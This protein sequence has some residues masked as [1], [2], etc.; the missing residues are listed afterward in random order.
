MDFNFTSEEFS[1]VTNKTYHIMEMVSFD[2][3]SMDLKNPKPSAQM[4]VLY[5]FLFLIV[6]V[7]GNFLLLSMIW[8]EKYGMDSKKRT[9]TNQLLSNIC[10]CFVIQN[11]IVMPILMF[12]RIY[13]P[14]L[15]LQCK[16]YLLVV[17]L[18]CWSRSLPTVFPHTVSAETTYRKVASS[19]TPRLVACLT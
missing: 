17:F 3:H 11:V 14:F 10:A 5:V 8:Y 7:F 19:S 18:S 15:I 4:L 6:E 13:R 2:E 16:I 9:V 1:V 12:H